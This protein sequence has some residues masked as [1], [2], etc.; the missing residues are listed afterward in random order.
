MS[1][2]SIVAVI[3][4]IGSFSTFLA[5]LIRLIVT[6]NSEKNAQ[7]DSQIAKERQDAESSGLPE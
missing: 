2:S 6:S 5:Y 4:A 7:I 1:I 3:T